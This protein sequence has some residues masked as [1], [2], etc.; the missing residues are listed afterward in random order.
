MSEYLYDND[1]GEQEI[2]GETAFNTGENDEAEERTVT[3]Y[4]SVDIYQ[5]QRAA[6]Q[7]A[8]YRQPCE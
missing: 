4:E 7:G 6:R 8:V 1:P 2:M 3:I 5:G